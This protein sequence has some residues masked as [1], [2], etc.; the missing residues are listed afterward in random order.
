MN[1]VF[2]P[3]LVGEAG[4]NGIFFVCDTLLDRRLAEIKV[5]LIVDGRLSTELR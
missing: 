4:R 3:L 5:V 1:V 2:A